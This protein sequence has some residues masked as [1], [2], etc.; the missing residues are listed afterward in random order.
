MGLMLAGEVFRK[1]PSS[2]SEVQHLWA[3][4]VEER[5]E[6]TMSGLWAVR[7]AWLRALQAGIAAG[8]LTEDYRPLDASERRECM[9][10]LCEEV[11]QD[12]WDHPVQTLAVLA[13]I[14]EATREAQYQPSRYL[15]QQQQQQPEYRHEFDFSEQLM[16]LLFTSAQQGGLSTD[17]DGPR[18]SSGDSQRDDVPRDAVRFD[19]GDGQHPSPSRLQKVAAARLEGLRQQGARLLSTLQQH[20]RQ[21]LGR[22]Q[23]H[24]T[25]VSTETSSALGIH[26]QPFAQV[27]AAHGWVPSHVTF[28]RGPAELQ[29]LPGRAARMQQPREGHQ[30]N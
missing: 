19:R 6:D 1:R 17:N 23:A 30:L 27:L 5:R 4:V 29:L 26:P 8:L 28:K 21:L 24:R 14:L 13:D 9:G 25:G 12:L 15:Q 22:V 20:Q 7:S 16:Y 10:A 18:T 2:S 3:K 11:G